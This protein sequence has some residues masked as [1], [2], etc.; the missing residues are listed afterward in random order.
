MLKKYAVF[1]LTFGLLVT[2]L[3]GSARA[4]SPQL[5]NWALPGDAG[6]CLQL[7][8]GS[9]Q[10]SR[11]YWTYYLWP[12]LEKTLQDSLRIPPVVI[13][14]IP[15]PDPPPFSAVLDVS[16]HL[17][18]RGLAQAVFAETSAASPRIA[19]SVRLEAAGRLREAL[20]ASI[21]ALDAEIDELKRQEI[22]GGSPRKGSP[23]Q[24]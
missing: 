24:D 10:C 7:G 23:R 14:P 5:W 18:E 11:V 3:G 9:A 4:Q 21:K 8:P 13:L 22:A 20:Q 15:Q 2:V 6:L 17:R 1:G 12:R 19:L 16:A